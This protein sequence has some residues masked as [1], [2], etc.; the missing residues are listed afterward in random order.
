MNARFLR[1]RGF[2]FALSVTLA[3]VLILLSVSGNLRSLES[4]IAFPLTIVS[5]VLNQLALRLSG[6]I[7]DLSELRYLRQRVIDLEELVGQYQ[8]EQIALREIQYD[9]NRMAALLNYAQTNETARYLAAEIIATET[10]GLLQGIII[11]RGSRDGVTVG[12]PV[13]TELGLVGRIVDVKANAAQ[14][15]LVTDVNSAVS[16]RLQ[17]T[18]AQGSVR[19]GFGGGLRMTLIPLDA[20]IQLNDIA[21][22]SGLGGNIPADLVIGQVSSIRQFEF[23]LFQ[24]AEVSS[25]IDFDALEFVLIITSFQPVDLSA[26]EDA[27]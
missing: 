11:N 25:L 24:E 9:F 13:V 14:V 2:L 15:L 26:F 12:M 7:E 10:S 23:E 3:L 19:G 6:D 1:N 17:S 22:T 5:G 8:S 16:S 20:V 18:R 4:V 27:G 21:L